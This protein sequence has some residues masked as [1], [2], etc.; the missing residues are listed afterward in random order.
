MCSQHGPAS[1][2]R[3]Q[4]KVFNCF[5]ASICPWCYPY[6][7]ILLSALLQLFQIKG[8]RKI[9]QLPAIVPVQKIWVIFF[10]MPFKEGCS[11]RGAGGVMNLAIATTA[12]LCLLLGTY[13]L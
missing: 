1:F 4:R 7:E 5:Q 9:P 13:K 8:K 10:V 2:D 11:H 3:S 12:I 6:L